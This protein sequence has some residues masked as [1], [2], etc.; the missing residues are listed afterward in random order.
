M[1]TSISFKIFL[2]GTPT[3]LLKNKKAQHLQ[4]LKS[5]ANRQNIQSNGSAGSSHVCSLE[6]RMT[7]T[8]QVA[9]F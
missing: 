6:S 5:G 9:K 4:F 3:F 8:L 1:G 7:M 2:S